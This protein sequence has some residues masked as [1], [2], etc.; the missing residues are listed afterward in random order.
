M[1]PRLGCALNLG[2]TEVQSRRGGILY[3]LYTQINE[4]T[5]LGRDATLNPLKGQVQA[6]TWMNGPYRRSLPCQGAEL[7]VRLRESSISPGRAS[8]GGPLGLPLLTLVPHPLWGHCRVNRGIGIL[9]RRGKPV[10]RS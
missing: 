10:P 2:A 7:R 8:I 3:H 1:S 5:F 9:E 4:R 6:H